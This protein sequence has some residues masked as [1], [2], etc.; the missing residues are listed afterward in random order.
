MGNTISFVII[1]VLI[2][3]LVA[4]LVFTY[5]KDKNKNKKIIEKKLN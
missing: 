2:F 5:I 4:F 3:F 1:G